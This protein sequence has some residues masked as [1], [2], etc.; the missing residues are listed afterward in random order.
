NFSIGVNSVINQDCRIDT[1]GC[2]KIGDNVSI[3]ASV[4]ILTAD[5][6]LKSDRFE[7]Q[8]KEITIGDDAFIGTNAIILPGCNIGKGA[9]LGAGSVLT[10]S[11]PTQEIWAGNPAKKI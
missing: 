6:N 1:R 9:G 5:H 4:T 8:I 3:S 10:R 2:V 7:G 11:I